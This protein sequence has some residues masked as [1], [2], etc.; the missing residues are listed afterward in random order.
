MADGTAVTAETPE[1]DLLFSDPFGEDLQ[2]IRIADPIEPVNRA[3]FWF[4]DKLYFYF[5][6]PVA[7]TFRLVPERE[8]LAVDRFFSNLSA[9]VRFVN[10]LLQLKIKD[11]GSELGRLCLNTTVGMGGLLDPAKS[12]G[13]NKKEEDF[14]QTLGHYG[15]GQGFYLVLPFLG[16]SSLRD[17]FGRVVDRFLD[18][19]TYLLNTWERLGS[20]GLEQVTFFSLD[21][22]TYES[23]KREALDPYLFMRNAYA[24][25]REGMVKK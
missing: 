9:P 13:M 10:S 14:G 11:A 24:Q 20:T 16:A 17:G 6:K 8:R 12:L 1:D 2:E 19:Q 5:L 22:D 15:V 21:K 3:F 25:R 4:N 23:I 18:P 7:R